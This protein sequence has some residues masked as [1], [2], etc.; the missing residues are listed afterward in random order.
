MV[1]PLLTSAV[2]AVGA[3]VAAV[4]IAVLGASAAEVPD[5]SRSTATSTTS[6]RA[7]DTPGESVISFGDAEV[8]GPPLQLEEAP[9]VLGVQVER[10]DEVAAGGAEPLPRTGAELAALAALG[11]ALVGTGVALCR[12]AQPRSEDEGDVAAAAVVGDGA[13][14]SPLTIRWLDRTGTAGAPGRG[15]G[16]GLTLR[17]LPLQ[18]AASPA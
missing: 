8:L 9:E 14:R 15:C 5:P 18:G 10:V 1:R 16:S 12:R 6:V 2:V 13:T 11:A 4:S 7:G 3:P 17:F